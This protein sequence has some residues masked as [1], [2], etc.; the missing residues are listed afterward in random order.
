MKTKLIA[1]LLWLLALMPG[2]R[3]LAAP[4]DN[5][6]NYSNLIWTL[7][8]TPRGIAT[9]PNGRVYVGVQSSPQKIQI[10]NQDGTFV[11]EFGS[12]TTTGIGGIGGIACDAGS[13]V[14]VFDTGAR[15]V[16][17][18]NANGTFLRE[19]GSTGSGDGQFGAP[20]G[21]SSGI[22]DNRI[23]CDSA[24]NVYVVDQSNFRIQKFTSAGVF[25]L[26]WGSS[27]ALAGQFGGVGAGPVALAVAPRD[28]V[29][30]S[31][32]GWLQSFDAYGTY[33][34][35][36]RGMIVAVVAGAVLSVII[37]FLERRFP[38]KPREPKPARLASKP[39]EQEHT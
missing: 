26:K 27:G 17:V 33:I 15:K 18:F 22:G 20:A 37:F 1:S 2:S 24:G 4:Q 34:E 7:S 31:S 30:V 16:Q 32:S 35:R 6:K 39:D 14:F 29:I 38:D 8:Q 28:R 23:G 12:F 19:W 25:L 11:S 21:G 13:N 3:L 36:V 9:A 5:W 10:F